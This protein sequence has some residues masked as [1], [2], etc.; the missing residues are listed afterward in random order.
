[1]GERNLGRAKEARVAEGSLG[2]RAA[3]TC[4]CAAISPD[5]ERVEYTGCSYECP[6]Y[7][8]RIGNERWC[9]TAVGR[10]A[11]VALPKSA[12]ARRIGPGGAL[13]GHPHC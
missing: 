12:F 9:R 5:I 2:G 11:G 3:A 8:V 4:S 13:T 6:A 7:D 1:M 10:G